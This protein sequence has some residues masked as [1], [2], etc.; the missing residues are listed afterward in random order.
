M[1]VPEVSI[2]VVK[3]T[4]KSITDFFPTTSHP[5]LDMGL[6]SSGTN[7]SSTA[8]INPRGPVKH[9][10]L[11]SASAQRGFSFCNKNNC[12]YCP[13]ID[14][15]GKITSSVTHLEH[16]SMK[17]V[18]CRSSNLIYAI[19][20]KICGMQYVGQTLLRIKKQVCPTFLR[21]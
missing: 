21:C 15:S 6:R 13:L 11:G 16:C 10:R 12:R 20:C 19:T 14:K 4:Q 2:S 17:K 8:T 1:H 5:N 7:L 9:S 18:S 3:S